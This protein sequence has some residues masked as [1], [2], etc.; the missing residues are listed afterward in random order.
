MRLFVPRPTLAREPSER[1]D[2]SDTGGVRAD[3]AGA[4]G[5]DVH[6]RARGR[7]SGVVRPCRD[8]ARVGIVVR[9]D[10]P[11]GSAKRVT[12]LEG[13]DAVDNREVVNRYARGILEPA[14]RGMKR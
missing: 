8:C 7:T 13:G 10:L 9:E 4:D 11:L 6:V 2:L 12:G 5:G 14:L 3:E 1:V